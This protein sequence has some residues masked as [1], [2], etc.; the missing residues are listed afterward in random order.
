M[1]DSLD[2]IITDAKLVKTALGSSLPLSWSAD[3]DDGSIG[4]TIGSAL[5]IY[6]DSC[7]EKIDSVSAAG[8]EMVELVIL[9]SQILK[10]SAAIRGS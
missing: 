6:V 4:E 9:A 7:S 5:D 1:S 10:D 8:F 3:A 2:E